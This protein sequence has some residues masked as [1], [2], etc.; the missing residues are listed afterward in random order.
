MFGFV[1]FSFLKGS[2]TEKPDFYGPQDLA[3]GSIVTV[4]RHKF[5]IVGADL[6]VLKFAEE[7]AAQFPTQTIESLRQHLSGITGRLD[8]RERSTVHL[9]RRPGD[10]ERIYAEIRNK[11]KSSRI[12]NAEELRQMFLRYD[13]DRTGYISR[14]NVKDLFRKICLPLDNDII[15]TVSA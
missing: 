14:D 13:S 4:F 6:Y 9:R 15:D 1:F 7:N 8:A 10:L 11:L 2:S 5:R 12:T 3:I